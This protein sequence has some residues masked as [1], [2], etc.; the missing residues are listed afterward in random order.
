MKTPAIDS[1]C[2]LA[3]SAHGKSYGKD[4]NRAVWNVHSDI[5]RTIRALGRG[6]IS[7][8]AAAGRVRKL[9]AALSR[10]SLRKA[11]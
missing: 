6:E 8:K 10:A 1:L 7:D 9:Q 3:S 11:K 4:S 5:M 2:D